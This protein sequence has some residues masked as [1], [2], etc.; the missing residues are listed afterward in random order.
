MNKRQRARLFGLLALLLCGCV[1]GTPAWLL[2]V[3]EQKHLDVRG[4]AQLPSV[5]L[6]AVPPPTTV[7]DPP[8]TAVP[9]EL[10]LD[11][12][13]RV[14]LA[15]SK[16]VRVLAGV[17]AVSSGQT[18]YDPAISNTRIDE[19]R[20][21]FDPV[22]TVSAAHDRTEQPQARFDPLAP[23]GVRITGS[24]V[25]QD[26]VSVG[27]AKQTVTGGTFR[28]DFADTTTRVT[29]GVLPLNP[30]E[31]S[32]TTLSYTQPLLR[33]AG[34]APNVAP[35]V[36]ARLNT[37]RSYFQFKD[38]VQELVRGVAE[39]Y[40]AVVFARTDLWARKQ[41]VEQAEFGYQY[42]EARQRRGFATQ[43]DVAQAKVALENF[44]ANRIA[45]EANLLQRE[46]ALR[47]LLGLPPDQPERLVLTTP[48]TSDLIEPD[49]KAMVRLA[50]QYRP[51]LIELKL[52][53]EADQQNLIIANNQARPQLDVTSFYRWNGL[54]GET[55]TGARVGSAAGEFTDWSLGVNF[56]VPLGLR[57]SRANLRQ[58][59]LIILRDKANLEQGLHS[60][61]HQLA[62]V[63]RNL[64]QYYAQY[65]A[66]RETRVAARENLDQQLAE[67][68]A[69]RAIYLNVL[70]AISDWGNAVSAEAQSLTAYNAELANLE[71]QTGTI[72][73]THGIR[74]LEERFRS[75][76]PLG[77][78]GPEACYPAAVVPGPNGPRYPDSGEPAE[79]SFGLE[80]PASPQRP[81]APELPV[82]R[83]LLLPPSGNVPPGRKQ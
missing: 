9:K 18:I 30:E 17:S 74:F 64:A 66:F 79:N 22:L 24:R 56:S 76:G 11:E 38:S 77:R 35:I 16:V 51:D 46:A 62:I 37:E 5:P 65:R 14:G 42:A 57:Q 7:T 49:W 26:R 19:A 41:Q 1:P 67:F 8:P 58:V 47:N 72:L 78:L 4:P 28:L 21:A 10:S 75:I 55:P 59:E 80:R 33:G 34:I 50:E 53:L 54:E 43:A 27:L 32:A 25:D 20:A 36:I 83:P 63:Y 69:G 82:P 71:R 44:R 52:I 2:V 61:I 70:Q 29:P 68:R 13:I 40:W 12:A 48:P 31:R 60:A 45:A 3:P 23:G 81:T 6:P 73:E 39:A 15:N